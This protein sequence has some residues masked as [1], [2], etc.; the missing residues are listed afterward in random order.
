MAIVDVV[1]TAFN[2]GE[3]VREAVE[4]VLAQTAVVRAV[5]VVDDGSSDQRSLEVLAE[6]PTHPQ[7][8]VL[9]QGNA[10]VSA[11][12]NAGIRESSAEYLL[13]LDGDDL[14]APTFV[15]KCLDALTIN[16]QA[17]AA[18]S[19]MRMFGVAS[20][21][22]RPRGGDVTA[23]L[24]ANSS[25]AC[26]LL[27]RDAYRKCGGYDESM[28]SG[29]EDWDFFLSLLR[30]GGTVD[31]VPEE[32]ISYRTAVT[33]ANIASMSKRT[34]L[35][36]YLV[37]KHSAVFAAHWRHALVESEQRST[38]RLM[39]WESLA[40]AEPKPHL[41]EATYGDGGMAAVVRLASLVVSE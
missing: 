18:T 24:T 8:K 20:A 22:V 5:T 25:P 39:A 30:D 9:R 33:S 4:S 11:A 41:M 14:V 2:Q 38:E 1:I 15:E 17:K 34:E 40:A 27:R 7:V 26:V 13:V 12:R 23:F 21:S 37:D 3:L 28:R 29:F 19:W 32:L 31:V 35:Y 6:L 36:G 10:G 16:R